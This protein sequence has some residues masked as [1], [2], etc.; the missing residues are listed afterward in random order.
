MLSSLNAT[1]IQ[2]SLASK[3]INVHINFEILNKLL[4][5][6][7]KYSIYRILCKKSPHITE[8][9]LCEFGTSTSSLVSVYATGQIYAFAIRF[10]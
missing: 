4:K 3:L 6:S 9:F 1:G 8:Q 7:T 10:P 2:S 5:K